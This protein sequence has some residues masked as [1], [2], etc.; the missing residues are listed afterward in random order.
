MK[1]GI[2]TYYG[3]HSHGAVLQ[4]NA[5][6]TVLTNL[7][8]NVEFIQFNRNYDFIPQGNEKK[9]SMRLSNIPYYLGYLK[10][11]GLGNVLYNI[12]K[13]RTLN[14]FRNNYF[15]IGKRF[16][17]FVADRIIIGS[18]EVFSTEIGINPFMYGHGLIAKKVFSYAGSFGP[19]TIEELEK[20]NLKK[21]V[22]SGLEGLSAIGVRDYN[23]KKIVDQLLNQDKAVLVCDPVILYGYYSEINK[24]KPNKEK[25]ILVYSYDRNM[26]D[27]EEVY[28]I[29]KYAHKKGCNV[30]S[31]AYHHNWCDKNINADPMELLGWIK[32]AEMVITDTFHGSVISMIAGVQFCAKL[33][34]N[35]N[36]LGFLLEQYGLGDRIIDS[37]EDMESIGEINYM[38]VNRIIDEQRS[39]SMDF[40]KKVLAEKNDYY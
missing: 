10:E 2:L 20:K 11:R 26:N 8:H 22:K 19:T 6:K 33:R 25:Y 5:L 27:P 38:I 15:V 31:V 3:V 36:K 12:S 23:S 39:F 24:F 13:N 17:D 7:G 40:L 9:Y 18:D 37:F 28:Q 32:N 34:G 14:T 21:L 35:Q 30:Y 4:A 16:S 29:L 1:I